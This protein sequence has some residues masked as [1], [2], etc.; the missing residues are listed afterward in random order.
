MAAQAVRMKE[1]YESFQILRNY[2][3]SYILVECLWWPEID[4]TSWDANH[5][6]EMFLLS[7]WMEQPN[8]RQALR[9][10]WMVC[11]S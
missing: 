5:L 9:S 8:K 1:W 6:Y 2:V 7:E 11:W 4:G 10:L 3:H